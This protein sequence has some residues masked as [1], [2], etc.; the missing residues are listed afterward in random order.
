MW[1]TWLATVFS[2][3]TKSVAIARF[4]LPVAISDST[5]TIQHAAYQSMT[6]QDRAR[7]HQRFADWLEKETSDPPPELEEIV[8]YHLEQAI[9]QLRAIGLVDT[10]PAPAVRAG[11]RLASADER[12]FGRSTSRRPRTCCLGRDRCF[13][14]RNP[15][16]VV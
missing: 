4:V 9:E 7:L 3:I 8:G 2:L 16:E 14:S 15:D 10:I 6:R 11:D 1:L 13:L 5:C 12:A